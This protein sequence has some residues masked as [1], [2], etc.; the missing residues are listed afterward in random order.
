MRKGLW[1][2][3]ALSVMMVAVASAGWAV[4][5][6]LAGVSL[7]QRALDLLAKPG[8]GQPDYVGPLGTLGELVTQQR[9]GE[10][11]VTGR[12]G[13]SGPVGPTGTRRG[14]GPG[15]G[16]GA[17]RRMRG[18]AGATTTGLV[19]APSFQTTLTGG[20]MGGGGRGRRGRR[21]GAG[22]GTG[23]GGTRGTG[24]VRTQRVSRGATTVARGA[25][26]PGM[27]WYYRRPAGAV[28]VLSLDEQG[29]VT[30]ITLSGTLPYPAGRTSRGIGLTSTYMDIIAQYGYP[31][32]TLIQGA[33]VQ[34]T[35]VDHGV[36]FQLEGMRVHEIAIGSYVTAGVEVA[37][38][39]VPES[40][41]PPAGLSVEELRGYL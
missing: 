21:G 17:G 29:V 5:R 26:G 14:R 9:A 39:E 6:E 23:R 1:I 35:Y 12:P 30:A 11:A 24:A 7:G 25:A 28:L 32:Q 19:R 33:A 18:E 8:F 37:P 3:L 34:L 38:A 31:D 10:T 16:M 15:Q 40:V 27:Y 2:G 13:Q 36:R 4:E 41:T 20:M 22:G